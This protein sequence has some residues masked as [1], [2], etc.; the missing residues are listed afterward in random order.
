[1]ATAEQIKILIKAHI[2]SDNDKFKTTVLQIAAYEAK[3]GHDTFARELK[4]FADKI[5]KTKGSV[6]RLNNPN[7]MFLM[8]IPSDRLDDL[9]VSEELNDRIFRILSE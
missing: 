3:H 8:G 1:M 5:G 4:Q 9:I 7:G 2:D 6:L